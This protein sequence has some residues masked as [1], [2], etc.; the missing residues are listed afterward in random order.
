MVQ[1][2]HRTLLGGSRTSLNI[3]SPSQMS[4]ELYK[5]EYG[6]LKRDVSESSPL[7]DT[8]DSKV[9]NALLLRCVNDGVFECVKSRRV[10]AL[11]D[12]VFPIVGVAVGAKEIISFLKRARYDKSVP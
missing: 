7:D 11:I 1:V 12:L 8:S 2:F 5:A 4:V 3:V 10:E 9:P 6:H